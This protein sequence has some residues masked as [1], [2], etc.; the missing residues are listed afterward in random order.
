MVQNNTEKNLYFLSI[1]NQVEALQGASQKYTKLENYILNLWLK[2]DELL[3]RVGFRYAW[4]LFN[5][6]T[7]NEIFISRKEYKNL[8]R[9]A[10]GYAIVYI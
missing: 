10:L 6:C 9:F 5:E 2:N 3:F 1:D 7:Q 8:L 4:S